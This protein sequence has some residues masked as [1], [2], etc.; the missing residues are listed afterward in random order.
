MNINLR[1]FTAPTFEKIRAYSDDNGEIRFVAKDLIELFE[2]NVE[3]DNLS[4]ICSDVYEIG[5]VLDDRKR[6]VKV[7]GDY[8]VSDIAMDS[9]RSDSAKILSWIRRTVIPTLKEEW[10]INTFIDTS[11]GGADNDE[12]DRARAVLESLAKLGKRG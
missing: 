11:F 8:G 7:V 10:A 12:K 5:L 6:I 2:T 9:T 4:K 3:Y 1:T